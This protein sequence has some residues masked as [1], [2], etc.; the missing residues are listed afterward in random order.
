MTSLWLRKTYPGDAGIAFWPRLLD[1]LRAL[2]GVRAA[3]LVEQLPP[4]HEMNHE[5]VSFPGRSASDRDEPDWIVD[6]VQAADDAALDTLGARIVRGRAFA[7]S[8]AL[9]APA[10]A[11]VNESFAAKYFRGREPIGQRI[12]LLFGYQRELR[13]VGVFADIKREAVD[14]P[15]GTE[16]MTPLQQYPRLFEQ[17]AALREMYAVLRTTDE[18]AALIPA[19]NRAVAEIDPTLPLFH[20]HTMDD[21]LWEAI[22]RP[23]FLMFLL[24]AFAGIALLLAAVGIY[25]VM[26]HT[27]A[28]RTHEIGLRVALGARPGQVRAMVLR[29]A[30]ALVI[31]G[32][33]IGLAAAIALSVALGA[34]LQGLFYGEPLAQ[35]ALLAAVAVAVTVTALLATWI[36][37]RR[38]TEVQP[39]VALR[40]E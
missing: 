19:V 22:A 26:S 5:G 28:Q 17:P 36:P 1:R 25:G 39:T 30:A 23:R 38:A 34:P 14:K 40:T 29:Q 18:P 4:S 9:D 8:D 35:P 15:A 24:T 27:V 6:F 7:A 33:A 13:V 16:L 21:V 37:V 20:V 12:K 10:V 31:A 2:P 11:L 3:S 32:V